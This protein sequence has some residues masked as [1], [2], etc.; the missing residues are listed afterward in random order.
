MAAY[1]IPTTP[2]EPADTAARRKRLLA[3][4]MMF[5]VVASPPLLAVSRA[6]ANLTISAGAVAWGLAHGGACS[7]HGDLTVSC[8]GLHGGYANGGTTVGNVWL[9]G[10][11]GG[12]E[13]HRHESRHSDQWALFGLA[14]P[15]LYGAECARTGGDYRQNVFEQWAGL[16]DGGYL[17]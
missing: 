13:R 4:L 12:T 7:L 5:V 8:G 9:Y 11:Y 16:H 14:F 1:P 10:E 17:P 6:V 2:H 15:A 3:A